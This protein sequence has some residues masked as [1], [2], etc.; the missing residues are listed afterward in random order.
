MIPL[1]S[2]P[3]SC[4]QTSIL[5]IISFPST[6][7]LEIR[8]SFLRIHS[9]PRLTFQILLLNPSY[10]Q[11]LPLILT[12]FT[13]H[14]STLNPSYSHPLPL[15]L[16]LLTPHTLSLYT[17][18]YHPLSLNLSPF[19]SHTPTLYLSYS[20]PYLS[21]SQPLSLILQPFISHTPNRPL[22]LILPPFISH[23]LTF[24][25]HPVPGSYIP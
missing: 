2:N 11:P 6:P 20:H 25:F 24:F 7:C 9:F 17:S 16:P 10:S 8:L 15:I 13:P 18:Y 3:L 22:S 4:F 1:D 23:T 21:Y 14:T 19:I 5:S 12:S